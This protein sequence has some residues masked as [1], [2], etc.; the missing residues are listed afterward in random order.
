[1]KLCITDWSN[2]NSIREV[3]E[4]E[5]L[6]YEKPY[7]WEL[8]WRDKLTAVATERARL[9]E[10]YDDSIKLMYELLNERTRASQ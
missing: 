1:M 6:L 2:P 3:S 4:K 5:A 9:K 7:I 8:Q 10:Q